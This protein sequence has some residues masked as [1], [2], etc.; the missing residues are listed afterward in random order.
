MSD[1]SISKTI[2]QLAAVVKQD[3]KLGQKTVSIVSKVA[4]GVVHSVQPSDAASDAQQ[5]KKKAKKVTKTTSSIKT[6]VRS[7]EEKL[8]KAPFHWAVMSYI[9]YIF[10]VVTG[11]L[12]ELI[13]GIGPINT[14][15]GREFNRDGYAPLYSSFEGFYT[16]NI[17]RRYKPVV[18]QPI[19]SVPGSSV[20]LNDRE[21]EDH[22]WT[23]KMISSK[24][25]CI[26]LGSYNYLGYAENEG[27]CTDSAV[28][29]VHAEGNTH[30]SSRQE[31]GN[32]KCHQI[33][34]ER[35]AE[36]VGTEDSITF[37]MGFATNSL[38]IPCLMSKGCL[39]ISDELNH[40]S[41]ILGMRLSGATV[42]VFKHGNVEH[43]E[44]ILRNAVIKGHPRTRRP[45]KKILIV[46]E[47]VYSMEGT[48]CRL[49]EIVALKKKYG[50][51]LYLDEAHSVGAMGPNGRGV[52]DYY[53]LN[54]H[55]IDI[56]MGTF[57]KSFG[58]AGG[59]LAGSRDLINHLRIHSQSSC[60]AM[61]VSPPVAMQVVAAMRQ[62][63]NR[64]CAGLE[65]IQRLADNSRYFRQRL[66]Q[67]GLIVYGDDDSP[68]IPV[69][70]IMPAKIR[71][72]VE[73]LKVKYNI[74]TVSVGFPA[75]PMTQE[76][77]RFCMSSSHNKETLDRAL[78]A[79][80][81][82]ADELNLRYSRINRD[83]D[84]EITYGS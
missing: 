65:R 82:I 61:S 77:A 70:L 46:V 56:M 42:M 38:N 59:Y 66:Q 36:F 79:I 40:A 27:P 25:D 68:V 28:E 81:K 52:V 62:I 54:P 29:S 67:M 21:S 26:N 58:A 11:Y 60:Y 4:N 84:T 76:R 3:M 16:R 8:E 7:M 78:E 23:S 9:S 45:W 44:K 80:D 33:L 5:A 72:F 57:T 6:R 14:V 63:M 18:G 75:V 20:L 10:L 74:A 41:L 34:E 48:I 35:V 64:E 15:F 37:G 50:A 17:F 32:L 22:Y 24:T 12:R 53:N 51:Y 69:L 30:C 49:P 73:E 43:L 2:D 47:G 55:D 71:A 31:L 39:I 13:W 19:T 83:K 1:L